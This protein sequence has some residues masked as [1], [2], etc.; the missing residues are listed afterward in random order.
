M[1]SMTTVHVGACL[2][3]LVAGALAA[4]ARKG[5]FVHIVAGRLYVGATL[6]Y[7]VSSFFLYPSTGQFTPFH[8]ISIQNVAMVAVGIALPRLLKHRVKA[9]RIWHLRLMLYS[10]V[11]LVVTGLRFAMPYGPPGNRVLPGLAFMVL[12]LCSWLWIERRVVPR[13]RAPP[14]VV[15]RGA[16]YSFDK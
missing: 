16:P 5:E 15:P 8:A 4:F 10:Y 3:A 12:P 2:L 9:W 1:R 6:I 14:V 11:A 7:G 13:W